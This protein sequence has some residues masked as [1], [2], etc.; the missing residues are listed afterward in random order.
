NEE[1]D[2]SWDFDD[3][4]DNDDG[5]V[6]NVPKGSSTSGVSELKE[7]N[8]AEVVAAADGAIANVEIVKDLKIENDE[9]GVV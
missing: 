8:S 7:D 3:D 2:L 6:P 4:D 9:K 1:E 5:Y